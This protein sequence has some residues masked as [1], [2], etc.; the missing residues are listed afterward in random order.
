[1]G[2]RININ[3]DRSI[4]KSKG[5]KPEPLI[6]LVCLVIILLIWTLAPIPIP[7]KIFASMGIGFIFSFFYKIIKL[8]K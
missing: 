3:Y 8:W 5:I 6:A 1:M 2:R 7:A 4:V